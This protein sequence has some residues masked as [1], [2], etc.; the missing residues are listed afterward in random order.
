MKYTSWC[1]TKEIE[2]LECPFCGSDPVAIHIGNNHT[3]IRKIVIKCPECRCQRKDA[4]LRN[5][6]EWLEKIS[7]DSWNKRPQPTEVKQ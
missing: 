5:G 1:G 2:L 6:F 7:A 3:K 4:A